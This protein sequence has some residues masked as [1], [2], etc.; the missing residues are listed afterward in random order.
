MM[1]T[2]KIKNFPELPGSYQMYNGQTI[3]YVGKAKNIKKRVLSYF[4]RPQNGK[5]AKLLTEITDIKYLITN[6]EIEAL[7]LEINLIKKH[8]PKYNILLTDDKSYPYIEY[9]AKPYPRLK[10]SRYLQLN[11]SGQHLLF[12][13]YP[14]SYAA[15]RT[16]NIINRLYPLKKCLGNPKKVCLY[17][18]INECLG[19][20]QKDV[21]QEK[22]A[23]M[24]T[25]I[26][27]FLK[28]NH[29]NIINKIK[30]KINDNSML[31][32][33]ELA[34]E[35]KKDLEYILLLNKEQTVEIK[36]LTNQDI[37]GY[38]EQSDYLAIQILFMRH[39]KIVGASEQ[40]INYIDEQEDIENYLFQFYEK[41]E[42]PQLLV[43]PALINQEL[44]SKTLMIKVLS[45]QKGA[46]KKLLYL[47]Q[48]NA[49]LKL[50]RDLGKYLTN[51]NISLKA[52]EELRNL[53]MLKQLKRI[54]VFDNSHLFGDFA[55]SALVVFVDGIPQ[56]KEYRK[57]KS[58]YL[59]KDDYQALS[60]VVY[61]RY[62]RLLVEQKSLPELIIVDGGIGQI[63]AALKVINDL[64]LNIKVVG[65]KKDDK[66]K[67]AQLVD[68]DNNLFAITKQS[69][70]FLYLTAIQDEVH[71]YTI[72]FHRQLRQ[73]KI[74]YSILDEVKGLG[75]KRKQLLLKKYANLEQIKQ[76]EFAE[77]VK[78]IPAPVVKE[79]MA[80][81]NNKA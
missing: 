39:G 75:P 8:L 12:G 35:L 43:V 74:K 36:D 79:L 59:Q 78:I 67:T 66:H 28:G 19:Y 80:L 34:S 49:E 26:L 41:H 32:N 53:L 76:A 72:N 31:L 42:K 29:Q 2:D 5:T 33:Y 22:I 44:L 24:Q 56:K 38:H 68:E 55:V 27:D 60:D 14:N 54:E 3:I 11:N 7:I 73:Q 20:C 61:R 16:V 10:V 30:Q 23:V 57:Y 52:N 25:E 50:N 48:K 69:N 9:I 15:K 17:Y 37:V 58:R 1:I 71:R 81:L 62:Y 18:H 65:L 45:P 13:P 4:N 63:H 70:L 6:N 77:L 21:N 40:I 64:H 46:K 51:E 47:A